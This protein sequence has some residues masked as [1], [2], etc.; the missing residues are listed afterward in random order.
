[1]LYNIPFFDETNI[2][3]FETNWIERQLI[4]EKGSYLLRAPPEEVK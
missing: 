2:Y 4:S 1:M 3:L